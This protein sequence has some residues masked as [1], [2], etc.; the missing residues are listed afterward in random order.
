MRIYIPAFLLFALLACRL[1]A[2]QT[3]QAT[4]ALGFN[5]SQIDG[6]KLFGFNQI[7]LNGGLRVGVNLSERWQ[8]SLEMRFSQQG[9]HRTRNDAASAALD[10]IRLNLVEVPL[11]I[12]F[13][14]WK[15]QAGGGLVYSRLVNYRVVDVNGTDVSE[16]QNFRDNGLAMIFAG[17]Y[18]FREKWGLSVEWSKYLTNLQTDPGAQRFISRN[19]AVRLLRRL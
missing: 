13:S 15:I 10:V 1:P 4:A 18:Y 2:Q 3:F 12:N 7:G 6:D 14:D 17:T 5:L 11:M 8:T 19:V 9:S 16:L